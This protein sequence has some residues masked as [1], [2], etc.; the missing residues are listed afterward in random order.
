MSP[1]FEAIYVPSDVRWAQEMLSIEKSKRLDSNNMA[2]LQRAYVVASLIRAWIDAISYK[3]NNNK[4]KQI[5]VSRALT[6]MD[7]EAKAV[8][9]R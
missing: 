1:E 5:K 6:A 3:L 7:S 4:E 2:V 8:S 9:P